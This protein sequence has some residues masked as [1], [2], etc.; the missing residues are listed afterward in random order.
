MQLWSYRY[1]ATNVRNGKAATKTFMQHRCGLTVDPSAPLTVFV[2]RLTDQKGVDVM[3]LG[4]MPTP[5]IAYI[6]QSQRASAGIVISAS[7]NPYY[8]NGVKFFS[9]EGTKLPDDI[10]KQIEAEM[11]KPLA[12]VSSDQLGK[13]ERITDAAGR[14]IEFCKSTFPKKLNLKPLNNFI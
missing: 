11:D 8:D 14:Y 6:T 12:T 7:H 10:E 4:P 2:G 13:V 9:T 1:D 5:A 3:L